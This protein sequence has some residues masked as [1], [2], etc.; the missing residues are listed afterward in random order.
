MNPFFK[1]L[2]LL[3]LNDKIDSLVKE[4][5]EYLD[6]HSLSKEKNELML[7]GNSLKRL[8]KGVQLNHISYDVHSRQKAQIVH[9]V[10]KL[11]DEI[12][13][14]DKNEINVKE[15]EEQKVNDFL[16]KRQAAELRNINY[17]QNLLSISKNICRIETEECYGTGFLIKNGWLLTTGYMLPNPNSLTNAEAQFNYEHDNLGNIKQPHSYKLNEKSLISNSAVDFAF[18]KL[19]PNKNSPNI[20]GYRNIEISEI[21]VKIDDV[22]SVIQ[23]P[24]GRA[25]LIDANALI[26]NNE[27]DNKIL[28]NAITSIGSGGAP[29]LNNSFE[30]VGI[31]MG[32]IRKMNL[33]Y[34]TPIKTILN[35]LSERELETIF[36]NSEII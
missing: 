15:K 36:G 12:K 27:D 7:I 20:K 29:I 11:I 30:L 28:Y 3:I 17:Y 32:E 16:N 13:R 25:K 4:L 21:P 6:K 2:E 31:H 19:K 22:V 24:E 34:F 35:A 26:V 10:T 8:E 1:N 14:N 9:S 18:V 23:H 33:M 5:F